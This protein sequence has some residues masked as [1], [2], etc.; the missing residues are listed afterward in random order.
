MI[1][2]LCFCVSTEQ[3]YV[4]ACGISGPYAGSGTGEQTYRYYHKASGKILQSVK[5]EQTE[6]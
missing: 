1:S 5:D 2:Y 6:G 3:Q 4:T